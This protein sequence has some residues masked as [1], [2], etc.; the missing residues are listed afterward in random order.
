MIFSF[1]SLIQKNQFTTVPIKPLSL[2]LL[3]LALCFHSCAS[4][5]VVNPHLPEAGKTKRGYAVSLE[6]VAPFLWYRVGISDKSELGL[7]LGLPIYGSGIDYSRLLYKKNNKWDMLNLSWSVNPNYN[8]DATYYKFKTKKTD[9]EFL[10]SRWIG[11]RMMS[12]QKGIVGHTSNR[13]GLLFGFQRNP[14]WGMEIG[15]FHDPT[16]IPF[17]EIF[18]TKWDPISEQNRDRFSKKPVTDK[19]S[20]FPSEFSRVTGISLSIFFDLD[21]PKK[22]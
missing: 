22:K 10:K 16:S 3:L 20:G 19:D 13:F 5:P 8:M 9:T 7:R 6:N 12:I 11:L 2:F 15:Y 1:F 18:N 17:T 4:H 21:A 14:R